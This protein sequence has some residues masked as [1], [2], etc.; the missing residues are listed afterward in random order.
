MDVYVVWKSKWAEDGILG[1]ALD[2]K[3]AN[4]M[5]MKYSDSTNHPTIEKRKVTYLA[6]IPIMMYYSVVCK[7]D[8]FIVQ[9]PECDIVGCDEKDLDNSLYDLDDLGKVYEYKVGTGIYE[10]RSLTVLVKETSKESAID[11]A[12]KLFMEYE[13]GKA[14]V[15][16]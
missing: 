11:T 2:E 15:I 9:Q 5:V 3:T 13:K 6:D 8:S 12:I 16:L 14:G 10:R 1:I 4:Y 7:M